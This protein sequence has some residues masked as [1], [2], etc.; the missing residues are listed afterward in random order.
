YILRK[1]LIARSTSSSLEWLS[2][3]R[4]AV[5]ASRPIRI[6]LERC[7]QRLRYNGGSDGSDAKYPMKSRPPA[8][9]LQKTDRDDFQ[10]K[11]V[12]QL[13]LWE[14]ERC[15]YYFCSIDIPACFG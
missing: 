6:G 4:A 13:N 14:P 7:G 11:T 10:E 5:P 8:K 9:R 2:L 3:S 15:L 12:C 1:Q